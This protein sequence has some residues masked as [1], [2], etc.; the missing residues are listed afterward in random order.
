MFYRPHIKAVVLTN[1]AMIFWFSVFA[2]FHY[3]L[4]NVSALCHLLDQDFLLTQHQHLT[5][6]RLD[7]RH[8]FQSH[9]CQIM[10]WYS[11]YK[12]RMN[13]TFMAFN[14]Q[15]FGAGVLTFIK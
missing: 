12:C 5:I 2:V 6:D 8:C 13:A 4:P 10:T 11:C 1:D 9:Y 15:A 14:Y 7:N 3:S